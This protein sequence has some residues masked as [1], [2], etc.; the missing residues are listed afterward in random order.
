MSHNR[1]SRSLTQPASMGGAQAMLHAVGFTEADLNKAQVGIAT[2]WW[3][4]NPCNAHLLELSEAVKASIQS[5]GAVG[6]R[7]C[8]A[9]VS[10]G[11]S[12]GTP[13]MAYSLPSRE[14]IADSVETV[15]GAQHYDACI[16]LP[17]C[18]K[19]LPG[20]AMGMIRIDRPSIIIYGG[21]IAAGCHRGAPTDI[22]SAFQAYG[23][24]LAGQISDEERRAIIRTACPG[25]GA[26]G[27]MYTA[28]TMAAALEAMGLMLPGGASAQ[29]LSPD[30]LAEA[31]AVGPAMQN[32]LERNLTPSRI[33]TRA[34][35][36]NATAVVTALGGSTNAVLHLLAI[37]HTAGIAFTLDDIHAVSHRT[38]R[39][40]DMKPS[41]RYVMTDLH[42]VGGVPAVMRHLLDAGLI[43]GEPMTVT[44][45]TVGH[46]LASHPSLPTDQDVIHPVSRPLQAHGHLRVLRG[47]LAP[48]GAI[49]KITGKEGTR[50]EGPARCFDDEA[51]MLTAL[52]AGAIREGDA[53]IIRYAGP[54]GGP[55]MPEMLTPTS[56]ISGA[57]LGGKVALLTDGRFSGGSHGFILGHITPEAQDGGPIALVQDGDRVHIDAEA[58]TLHVDVSPEVLASRRAAW[59]TPAPKRTR[60]VLGRFARLV[61]TASEGC[62]LDGIRGVGGS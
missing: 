54:R 59:T 50:F 31:H 26:C 55:G 57:G 43:D 6:L 16:A 49:A 30:K 38:P 10:D 52:E 56:A 40:A 60:G 36:A 39:L 14:L 29:A 24:H 20:V 61:S 58:R 46:N 5:A 45:R 48:E 15:L 21:T 4:G 1:V 41:G 62:T 27:G 33:L 34:S 12:M 17:G 3:E 11:I 28:N 51:A 19:N 25:P 44:G 8:T 7:F 13:G 53:V 47:N 22:V 42:R 9:G 18:D 2:V 23:Q 37:A 32:L 35:L